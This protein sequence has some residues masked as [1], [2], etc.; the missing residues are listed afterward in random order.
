MV[1]EVRFTCVIL[2]RMKVE[3][4][5]PEVF[6]ATTFGG[7]TGLLTYASHEK[8]HSLG[9]DAYV[10]HYAQV[11]D[12]QAANP[13][14]LVGLIVVGIIFALV[15]LALFKGLAFLYGLISSAFPNRNRAA[16]G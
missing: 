8:W 10:A 4:N 1:R 15:A 16:Q 5:L 11:F 7:V 6:S 2:G 13:P 3:I 12:R 9:R 14:H